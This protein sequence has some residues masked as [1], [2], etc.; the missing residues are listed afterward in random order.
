MT[1]STVRTE[2]QADEKPARRRRTWRIVRNV[3][4]GLL[5]AVF[6]VWLVLG[7]LIYFGYSRRHSVMDPN[8]P[9]YHAVRQD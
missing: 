9:R 5:G 3:V 8:S 6:A 1:V 4:L 2:P 7:L